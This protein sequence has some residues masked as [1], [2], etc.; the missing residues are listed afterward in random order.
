MGSSR[1][2]Q[3]GIGVPGFYTTFGRWR[4]II[5]VAAA[6]VWCSGVGHKPDGSWRW[7]EWGWFLAAF[8]H[9]WAFVV[10][11]CWRRHC[12][13][14]RFIFGHCSCC[15]LFGHRG[16][17]LSFARRL[18]RLYIVRWSYRYGR[19][20]D[21]GRA[22][23]RHCSRRLAAEDISLVVVAMITGCELYGLVGRVRK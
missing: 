12:V 5:Y 23:Q 4:S 21:S 1:C 13:L 14:V 19:C 16:F 6:V 2:D 9:S 11:S 15:D 7:C 10:G 8:L 20:L 22:P 17:L 18:F 3:V